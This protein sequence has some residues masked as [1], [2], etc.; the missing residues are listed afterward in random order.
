MHATTPT[1]STGGKTSR[2]KK[3]PRKLRREFGRFLFQAKVLAM[4]PRA[5]TARSRFLF[6][7]GHM[8]SGST[9]LCHLLCNSDDIVGFG[10]THHS[11]RR[12][13]DLAKLLTSVGEHT[14][15]APLRYRYVLDKIVGTRHAMSTAV[16][17]DR[18][19]RYVFLVRE[20]VATV[21]SL[22]AMRRQFHDESPQQLLA[23]AAQ[24]YTERLAQL[25]QLAETIGDRGR[26]L[27][28]THQQ[29]LAETQAAFQALQGFLV[30]GAPL[31]EDYKIMST[32]G[33]PGIGDPCPNIRLGKIVRSLPRKH[34]D[35][36]PPLRV[37]L[38]Q[39]YE[40]CLEKLRATVQTADL[41]LLTTNERAA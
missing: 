31:C 13:S 25:L 27:L 41:P 14:A 8:R 17:R 6:I 35:L 15:K 16:L 39:R 38:Q 36:P 10:E 4:R 32:T 7:L 12:R 37:H 28:L 5:L 20:P 29:L 1:T 11:Y 40:S 19:T 33:Q 23:F 21:A 24:H 30:L 26:C 22:V 3:V 9:L 34:V 18:R 2:I